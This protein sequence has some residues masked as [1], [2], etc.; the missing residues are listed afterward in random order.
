MYGIPKEESQ[1]QDKSNGLSQIDP[2]ESR[3]IRLHI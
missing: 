1:F 3:T 2:Q